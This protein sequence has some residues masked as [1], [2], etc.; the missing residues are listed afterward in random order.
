MELEVGRV[1][2]SST[3]RFAAGCLV[4]R[5]QVPVFAALVKTRMMGDDE[6]FGVIHNVCM[7]DDPLVRQMAAASGTLRPEDV[8]DARQ[9]RLQ[10]IEVGVL[11]VGYRQGGRLQ[12]RLPPQPP[13]SLDTIHTCLARELVEF[14]ARSDYFPLI[15]EAQDLPSDELL[16]AHL[17]YAAEARGDGEQSFLVGAGRELARLLAM[18]PLRLD[19]ILRRLR[20]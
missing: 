10:P 20:T 15:L 12:H 11:V 14:T 7:E 19:G 16:A 18:E 4:L 2:R 5:P 8:E 6:V 13:L 3:T 17:R 9:N 1:I